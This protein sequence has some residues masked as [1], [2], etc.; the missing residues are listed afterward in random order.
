M[1][2]VKSLITVNMLEFW[3]RIHDQEIKDT[4][5]AFKIWQSNSDKLTNDANKNQQRQ[6]LCRFIAHEVSTKYQHIETLHEHFTIFNNQSQRSISEEELWQHQMTFLK[7]MGYSKRHIQ[8]DNKAKKRWFGNDAI[9]DRYQEKVAKL[10]HSLCFLLERLGHLIQDFA[11]NRSSNDTQT[12]L[13]ALNLETHL[14]PLLH[15]EVDERVAFEA[16]RCLRVAFDHLSISI[17][18]QLDPKIIQHAYRVASDP[19]QPV[20]LQS[21]A[22]ALLLSFGQDSAMRLLTHRLKKPSG[23]NDDLFFRARSINI[24]FNYQHNFNDDELGA[25][26]YLVLEDP[27]IYVRQ[28]LCEQL[29]KMQEPM[30]FSIFEQ[31]IQHDNAPQVQAKAWIAMAPLLKASSH[32]ASW[33]QPADMPNSKAANDSVKRPITNDEK[34]VALACVNGYVNSYLQA[35][36]HQSDSMIL[37]L[38]MEM[39]AEILLAFDSSQI[40]EKTQFYSDCQQALSKLHTEHIETRVRRWAALAREK[41]WHCNQLPLNEPTLTAL[42]HLSLEQEIKIPKPNI[43]EQ[44]LGRRLAALSQQGVGFDITPKKRKLKVRGGYRLNFR[45]WRFFHEWRHPSTDKRQNYNHTKGRVFM[46]KLQVP[47]QHLAESSETQVPGEPV[48]NEKEHGWRPYLP[49]VDQIL[50]SLDQGWPTQPI[51]LYTSEGITCIHPPKNPFKRLWAKLYITFRFKKLSDMRNWH[52]KSNTPAHQYLMTFSQLGFVFSLQAYEEKNIS[53]SVDERVMRFFPS[54]FP[55]YSF[56]EFFTELQNYFYSVYQNTLE[57]LSIF[58][59]AISAVFFGQHYFIN[60]Q[61]RKARKIIPFV[62]GGWGTRGKSGTERLKAALF[63]A[64]GISLVSK[65][66][67]CEAQF[68]YA[69]L[70]R[71]LKELFLFRPYDKATIWEQLHL[72]RL[73]AKLKVNVLLWECMGLT[74]RYINI[75]Q[76]Q[77]MRD[78]LATITNCYPD[79]EDIQ[80]PSGID[81]PKVM[82]R[83]VPKNSTLITSED[84]MSPLLESAAHENNSEYHKISWH[85]GHFLAADIL[86]RFPYEEHPTNIALVLKMAQVLGFPEDVAIKSMADNVVPDLGVLKVYPDCHLQRRTFNLING[87]SANERLA[88][89]NNWH[90]LGLNEINPRNDPQIWLTTVVNNRAD[91]IARSQVFAKILANDLSADQHFL[92][93]SN[94]DGLL[95]YIEAQWQLRIDQLCLDPKDTTQ[96]NQLLEKWLEICNYLRIPKKDSDIQVRL[97]SML[98]GLAVNDATELASHWNSPEKLTEAL[99]DIEKEDL[100]MIIDYCNTAQKDMLLFQQWHEDINNEKV[101]I[102]GSKLSHHLWEWFRKRF[103]IIEDQH[104][105]GNELIQHMIQNTPPGLHNKMMGLQNIK[106]TGLDFIYRWQSWDNNYKLCEQLNGNQT[107]LAKNAAKALANISDFGLL[108]E[109]WVKETCRQVRDKKLAQ[110][111]LF[112]AELNNIES[113]IKQQLS[114]IKNNL[115]LQNKRHIINK[116]IDGLEAFLDAGQSVKRRRKAEKIYQDLADRRISLERAGVELQKINKDQKGG[117]LSQKINKKLGDSNTII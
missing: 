107:S 85:Q 28:Q 40:V 37:R 79:H 60:Q 10:E 98:Q 49:L 117:W 71:P 4:L 101:K 11:I 96:R 52:E 94:V 24:L 92:I 82:T 97:N 55:F 63:N 12:L 88:A 65:S 29:G 18:N 78:D 108:D 59:V 114:T 5:T 19:Y 45:L 110:T 8:K 27:S 75:L 84:S 14:D 111:E 13:K 89:L 103:I 72:T 68:L 20:W 15:Y 64:Y 73:A 1:E 41:L 3:L 57:Q 16:M 87:F 113:H 91:R 69:P 61:F 32:K 66:T 83:F 33:H 38:L 109:E 43:S 62:I 70:H 81:I 21:E 35:L 48:L 17:I 77:W 34:K 23:V 53:Q 25:L 26:I 105:S 86:K 42:N 95:K 115:G 76:Q 116:F 100:T 46:G 36:A 99:D 7:Y 74:P 112:Q 104:V 30:C 106:G 54:F 31:I 67:G 56:S 58:L 6:Q 51:K 47:A 44:E 22:L 9:K 80:G 90:R 93:G 102:D 2:N 50:S 39:A